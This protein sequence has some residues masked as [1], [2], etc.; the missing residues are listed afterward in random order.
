MDAI[1]QG[2]GAVA[3]M[4]LANG[5][6]MG[7]W[8]PQ[9]PLIL[10]RFGI[11]ESVLGLLIL[12]LGL[13]AV[14]AM[15]GSG[16]L[17]A[18][19]GTVGVLRIFAPLAMI[20]LLLVVLAPS[21]PLLALAMAVMGAAIGCMDVAMNANAVEVERRM[22]RA[23]MSSSHGF[24]SLGGFAGG[25]GGGVLI[26][27]MGAVGHA[28]LACTLA[29][30]AVLLALPRLLRADLPAT[31]QAAGDHPAARP[32]HWPKG[33]AIYILGLMALFS[34]VPEGAVL[35]WAALYL[36]QELGAGI[37]ASGLAFGAFSGAMAVMRF[38]GDGIR[39]RFGAAR[40]LRVS[41]LVAA[42][43]ILA[44]SLAPG[45]AWAV[46]AFA[47]AGLGIANTVPVVISAAGNHGG[48]QAGAAIALVTMM[49]YSGILIAPSMIGWVAEAVGFRWTF[50]AMALLLLV[51]AAQAGR[52]A[53]ADG[54][55]PG[56]H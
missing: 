37:A 27:A 9:I 7:S 18:R 34:M 42:A 2:R 23:I 48:A 39:N 36:K 15:A 17:I 30:L 11:T 56:R 51:V 49:G 6:V 26:A 45:S 4:F 50:A 1:R 29:L 22:G 19:F 33:L 44:A 5:F 10:P 53:G 52:A 21:M 46:L 20:A 31:D 35:D 40:V 14:G 13:G 32:G 47:L 3:A 54:A 55:G 12:V 28:A 24:W 16:W 38:A 8:A 41:A 43:G 25:M